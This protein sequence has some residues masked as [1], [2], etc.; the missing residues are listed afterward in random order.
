MK[1]NSSL[2]SYSFKGLAYLIQILI[3]IVGL[4]FN[5]HISDLGQ[6][7]SLQVDFHCERLIGNC[8]RHSTYLFITLNIIIFL[9][10]YFSHQMKCCH[11]NF[12]GFGLLNFII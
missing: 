7:V 2:A 9:A 8:L 6:F 11:K 4:I 5:Y 3:I 12:L 1:C 10:S